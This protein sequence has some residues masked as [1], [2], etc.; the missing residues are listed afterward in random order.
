V[1]Q[2]KENLMNFH[3]G[4]TVIHWT[5]GLG[6]I[7]RLEERDLLGVQTLYYAVQV[8]DMMVWVPSDQ[9]LEHRLRSPTSR[10][11]F[12]ELFA[13]LSDPGEPLPDNRR[14]RRSRLLTLLR[15]GSPHSLCRIISGLYA[16]RNI[17][18]L[19]ESDQFILKQARTVML[20]EWA[21]VLSVTPA[22]AEQKLHYWLAARPARKEPAARAA[23]K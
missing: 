2:Q 3:E 19:N 1:Y 21:F 6:R 16:H 5:H 14:E 8:R 23:G 12:E 20:E 15:D 18:A 4:D 10:A 17:Q 9:E 22:Q 11:G 13:I 7:V